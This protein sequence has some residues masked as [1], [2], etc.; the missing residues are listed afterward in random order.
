MIGAY[1]TFAVVVGI[2]TVFMLIAHSFLRAAEDPQDAE[3]EK[4]YRKASAP[5]SEPSGRTQYAH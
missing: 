2:V 1:I 4:K 3:R 5:R